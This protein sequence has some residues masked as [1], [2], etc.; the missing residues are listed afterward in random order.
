MLLCDNKTIAYYLCFVRDLM[1]TMVP[2]DPTV[3]LEQEGKRE[4]QEI[5]EHLDSMYK[6]NTWIIVPYMPFYQHYHTGTT[7]FCG[8][9]RTTWTE[10]EC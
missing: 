5:E 9:S 4:A 10:G 3:V 6:Y 2:L 8:I 1:V 7:W